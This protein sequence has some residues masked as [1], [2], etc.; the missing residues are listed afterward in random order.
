MAAGATLPKGGLGMNS[1]AVGRPVPTDDW[2]H[3]ILVIDGFTPV[4]LVLAVVLGALS[5]LLV[6]HGRDIG[7][8]LR[9]RMVRWLA[10][11]TYRI[12]RKAAFEVFCELSGSEPHPEPEAVLQAPT[13][14]LQAP[15]SSSSSS[16]PST[17][18]LA[19]PLTPPPDA[20][21]GP[22]SEPAPLPPPPPPVPVVPTEA[23]PYPP[24]YCSPVGDRWHRAVR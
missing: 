8:F 21:V 17:G 13:S 3:D 24:M 23:A 22:P 16:S 4:H 14:P 10:P 18:P 19:T 7:R 9:K 2:E 15:Q 20:V 12:D 11:A 1:Q 6:L 5:V